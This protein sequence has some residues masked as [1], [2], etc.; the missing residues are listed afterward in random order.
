MWFGK[1][2]QCEKKKRFRDYAENSVSKCKQPWDEKYGTNKCTKATNKKFFRVR[3]FLNIST[4]VSNE[5]DNG[6]VKLVDHYAYKKNQ[7]KSQVDSIRI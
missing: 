2:K 4:D 1:K 3:K 6:I 5:D 7:N